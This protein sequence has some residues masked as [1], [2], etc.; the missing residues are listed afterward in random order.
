VC[1]CLICQ[2]VVPI[3][4]AI[5]RNGVGAW[6]VYSV[7]K[8]VVDNFTAFSLRLIHSKSHKVIAESLHTFT[9]EDTE[10]ISLGMSE[11]RRS[12]AT[13]A[14]QVLTEEC[15]D[16][17]Q[18]QMGQTRTIVKKCC[19]ALVSSVSLPNVSRADLLPSRSGSH[20]S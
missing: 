14:G 15:L 13:E 7:Q 12:I 20:S 19:D 9:R 1:H 3:N 10:D 2:V 18:R 17:S 5:L 8:A 11:L 16:A 6:A 4:G